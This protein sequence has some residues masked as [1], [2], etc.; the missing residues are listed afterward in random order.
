MA[1]VRKLHPEVTQVLFGRMGFWMFMSEDMT[2][3][4]FDDSIDTDILNAA[5]DFAYE[6]HALPCVIHFDKLE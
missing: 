1:H 4:H 6:H 2:V 5:L 3:P